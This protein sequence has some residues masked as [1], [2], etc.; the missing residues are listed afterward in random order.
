MG[1][2]DRDYMRQADRSPLELLRRFNVLHLIITV[3]V[4]VFI[5]QYALE[6]F[7]TSAVDSSGVPFFVPDG[8]VSVDGLVSGRFWT[9]V[10]YMFVHGDLLHLCANMLMVWFVGRQVLALL[11]AR[12]FL[13]VY[14]LS[15]LVGAA[16]ELVVQA[17]AAGTTSYSI[18]GAS[19]SAFGL[20]LALAVMFP[21]EM[22]TSLIYFIFPV[23]LRLWT[24][25]MIMTGVSL[26]LGVFF[27]FFD[28]EG[29]R[30]ANF[31]HVGGALTGWY[32]MRLLGYGSRFAIPGERSWSG[33]ENTRRREMVRARHRRLSV[34]LEMEPT[35]KPRDSSADIIRDEVDPILEKISDH[36]I[37]SLTDDERRILERA[38]RTIGRKPGSRPD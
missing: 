36:G 9:A 11:G 37:G 38:S 33:Q 7:G 12:H 10:T 26:A 15:G 20:V 19:A 32:Y 23:R 28:V 22:I 17:Y 2:H 29:A 6:L 13:N 34:N 18:I 8:G 16:A 21:D 30:W 3:N 4:M 31:A 5:A 24:L 35:V 27:L 25:A 1:L 14:F